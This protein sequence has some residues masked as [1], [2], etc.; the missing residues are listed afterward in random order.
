MIV[1]YKCSFRSSYGYR[2]AKFDMSSQKT[3]AVN[4]SEIPEAISF[5]LNT[6]L[7]HNMVLATD[8]NGFPF[9]GVFGME[10][11]EC[12]KYINAVF[13][14]PNDPHSILSLYHSFSQNYH[15]C[16]QSVVQSVE[17]L[18]GIDPI[19]GLEYRIVPFSI[20]NEI[21]TSDSSRNQLSLKA[22]PCKQ[23]FVFVSEDTYDDYKPQIERYFSVQSVHQ[24]NHVS[25]RNRKID[26]YEATLSLFEKK[27]RSWSTLLLGIGI[28][29]V[30]LCLIVILLFIF[31]IN[32]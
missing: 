30:V 6:E 10:D 28:F 11:E 3:I 31:F 5:L 12:E 2:T 4:D 20:P 23:L 17:R 15:S 9:L 22:L 19:S 18:T 13:I 1:F 16:I 7:N 8:E 25:A 27:H 14:D 21:Q 26:G 29:A 24:F 32:G